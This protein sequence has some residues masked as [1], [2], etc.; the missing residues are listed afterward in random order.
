MKGRTW[1]AGAL[2]L[3]LVALCLSAA[4]AMAAG[5]GDDPSGTPDT[6]TAEELAA[7]Q[8]LEQQTTAQQQNTQYMLDAPY[9]FLAT[10]GVRQ[11]RTYWCGPATVQCI[12]WYFGTGGPQSA[13]ARFLGTTT[14]GT[15]F[16]RV[17]DALRYY[18][19]KPY[20]YYGDLTYGPTFY[21]KL[22]DT[23]KYHAM[24]VAADMNIIGSLF[25]YYMFDHPGHIVPVE[26]FDWRNS[27][28]R[29]NDVYD[30]ERWAAGGDT[31]G[32]TTYPRDV[33]W[34]GV[35]THWRRAIVCAP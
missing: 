34:R 18:T 29:L 17:D 26:G 30:E 35:A 25:P 21:G 13:F 15:N 7:K 19:G 28:L 4:P 23:I 16:S 32:R 12:S 24:P 9:R 6:L 20:Y 14:S 8:A 27:T 31:W 11:E 5:T 22:A 3:A 1:F 33:I 2:V 10:P